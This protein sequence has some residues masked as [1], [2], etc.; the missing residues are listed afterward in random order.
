MKFYY[1]ISKSSTPFKFCTGI[2]PKQFNVLLNEFMK[3]LPSKSTGRSHS[4]S[5]PESKLC[6]I[7][8]YYRHYHIQWF[9][10]LVF[11]V[12]Q[13]QISRWITLYSAMLVKAT[14]VYITQA[15]ARK[16]HALNSWDWLIPDATERPI[17]TPKNNQERVYSGKKKRHTIKNQIIIDFKQKQILAFSD[18]YIGKVH[19]FKIFKQNIKRITSFVSQKTRIIA[20]SG[21]VGMETCL[22]TTKISLPN[23]A[24]KKFPLTEAEK[25]QNK[26]LAHYR[27]RVEHVIGAL[28]KF[29][30]L[31]DEFR[32][33][34]VLAHSSFAAIC[35]LYNLQ[36]QVN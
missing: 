1:L 8:F 15:S 3:Y 24:S 18:T 9:L 30:I 33:S 16:F 19:D 36:M 23:K 34:N 29:R 32:G 35:G 13:S 10:A 6:F 28:K 17:N 31:F 26:L 5:T 14:S 20:D 21:Y 12:N 27:V 2:S 7:L 4:L 11:N 25:K 22:P